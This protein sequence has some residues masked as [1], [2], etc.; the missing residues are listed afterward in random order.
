M[1]ASIKEEI[2]T[3]MQ[4]KEAMEREIA[5]RMARLD[6]PGQPGMDAPLMDREVRRP[7]RTCMS[8]HALTQA[9]NGAVPRFNGGPGRSSARGAAAACRAT[10]AAR[11]DGD[12]VPR[13]FPASLPRASRVP[14]STCTR[15]EQT[16]TA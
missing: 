12:A 4:Q 11:G 5:E 15:S 13:G 1:E 14:T 6:A 10:H 2:R 9:C 8:M 16:A 3:L 7:G